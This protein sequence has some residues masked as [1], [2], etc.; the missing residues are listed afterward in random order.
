MREAPVEALEDHQLHLEDL[1]LG[2]GTVSHIG[3]LLELWQVD[4]L[5][6]GADEEAADADEL[7]A[8]LGDGG[9]QRKEPVN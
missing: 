8:V 6:I 4:L 2:A 7:E 9:R 3:E 5:D 1:F